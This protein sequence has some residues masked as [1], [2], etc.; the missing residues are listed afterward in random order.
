M[1]TQKD[2]SHCE[3]I[4]YSYC[5]VRWRHGRL[6]MDVGVLIYA[7]EISTLVF[8][9]DNPS[10]IDYHYGPVAPRIKD[11]LQQMEQTVELYNKFLQQEGSK[12]QLVTDVI[13]TIW[14]D[15]DGMSL[16]FGTVYGGVTN[17]FAAVVQM[18]VREI[19]ELSVWVPN[20][21]YCFECGD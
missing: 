10:S 9:W 11:A 18:L 20:P 16:Q 21:K 8:K 13:R 5:P 15:H 6:V 19:E 3:S 12:P 2:M 7:P 1:C 4:A 14:P 17:S